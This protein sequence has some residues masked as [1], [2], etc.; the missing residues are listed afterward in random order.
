MAREYDHLFKLLIIGDSGVGKSSLLLR[1]SDNTFAGTYITTIG[2]D[3]KIR[4]VDV[5]GEKVKLQIWD[6]AGQE[7]FRTITS[8]YYR[9]THGVIVVYD[10]T[11]GESFA[12]VKRWLHEI[13]QNCDVVNRILVGNK[14]DDPD[15]K[16]VLT[17][18]AQRFAEQMG[19]QLYETSAKEN[20]NV[21]E[22]FLAITK[23]VL[24][25]KKEQMKKQADQPSDSIKINGRSK[26][27]RT[28]KCC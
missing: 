4:T 19:I 2:V 5:G 7:R 23:L 20:K 11:S 15:R 8:T 13:D 6:T 1:F 27:K 21:E 18:D 3:F 26:D 28:K 16:V 10:V 14:D 9:G 22:M 12:N 24:Q 17:Q 25:S